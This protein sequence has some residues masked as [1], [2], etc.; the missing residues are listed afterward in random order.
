MKLHRNPVALVITNRLD[1]IFNISIK[2]PP[3]NAH[4]ITQY[5]T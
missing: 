2:L 4:T 1:Y 5:R 3:Q